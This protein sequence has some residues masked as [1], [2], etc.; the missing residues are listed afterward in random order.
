MGEHTEDS[1]ERE[2]R[3]YRASMRRLKLLERRIKL[4]MA[5]IFLSAPFIYLI[6]AAVASGFGAE[7]APLPWPYLIPFLV[8][9]LVG[10]FN[11]SLRD[12][13]VIFGN[14][15]AAFTQTANSYPKR[16]ADAPDKNGGD[17]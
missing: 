3:E 15:G 12:V 7:P 16:D 8:A 1:D 13:L 14:L 11:F 17:G 6:G 10:L 4:W 5:V 9:G 2:E